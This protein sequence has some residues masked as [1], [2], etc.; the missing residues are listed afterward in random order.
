[1]D[2]QSSFGPS[3]IPV[4][5]ARYRLQWEEAQSCHVLLYPEGM[6]KLSASASEIVRRIDGRSSVQALIASLEAA[7]PGADLRADVFE[8]LEAAHASGWIEVAR[9]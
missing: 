1:M 8:F 4:L 5:P 7:F 6:I 9:T 3:T 2:K